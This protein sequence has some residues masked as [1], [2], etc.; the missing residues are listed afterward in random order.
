MLTSAGES[1]R[2][3]N[4]RTDLLREN[5]LRLV[6]PPAMFPIAAIDETGYTHVFGHESVPAGDAVESLRQAFG[7]CNV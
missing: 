4:H 5:R 6:L 3:P 2:Q 1:N 7:I